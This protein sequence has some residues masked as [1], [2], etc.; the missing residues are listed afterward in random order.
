M[1]DLKIDLENRLRQYYAAWSRQDA[2]AVMA[3]FA[4]ESTFED[5]AFAARFEGLEQIRSFVDLTYAGSPDFEV[6]PTQIVCDGMTAAAAWTMLGT[7]SGDFPDLP[8]TGAEFEVRACSVVNFDENQL[9]RTI[10][11]Y[12]NPLEFRACVGLG[13]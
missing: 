4:A 9:I 8:A 2:E 1:S 7:H 5:L 12:W 10:V 11:D 13:Q 3:F 6:R